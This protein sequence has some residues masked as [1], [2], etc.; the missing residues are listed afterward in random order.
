MADIISGLTHKIIMVFTRLMIRVSGFVNF[1]NSS[2]KVS[3]TI[4][5]DGMPMTMTM[6]TTAY[7]R[8]QKMRRPIYLS[9]LVKTFKRQPILSYPYLLEKVSGG[10]FEV[11]GF[12]ALC[13]FVAIIGG[14]LWISRP[15]LFTLARSVGINAP[16]LM[17]E[18]LTPN[19]TNNSIS[20]P[21][22]LVDGSVSLPTPR[23]FDYYGGSQN[24][25]TDTP[26]LVAAPSVYPTHTPYPTYTPFPTPLVVSN[27]WT[28]TD[29]G[30][31]QYSG[32]AYGD[33]KN[34]NVR[35]SYYWPPLGGIN[36]SRYQNQTDCSRLADGSRFAD[37]V[38]IAA[39]CP[40][41]W[42]FG[43]IVA[44]DGLRFRCSDRGGAIV[45]DPAIDAYWIDILYPNLEKRY[46]W[47]QVVHAVV[48][49]P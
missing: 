31:G 1:K 17:V 20:T 25:S 27:P 48:S 34:V 30:F 5:L 46:F 22:V 11:G 40:I 16:N 18:R 6:T 28:W 32:S 19:V 3:P 36:C 38:G 43:S 4:A 44:F 14:Y 24:V 41:D 21:N 9:R 15:L 26:P 35:I 23:R 8:W 2:Q 33:V 49:L 39:A 13:A 45:Y 7:Q 12:L 37:N 10:G 47:G 29:H 42:D